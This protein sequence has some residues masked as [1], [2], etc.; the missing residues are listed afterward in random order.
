MASRFQSLLILFLEKQPGNLSSLSLL[1]SKEQEAYWKEIGEKV[2]QSNSKK[3][4]FNSLKEILHHSID[5]FP[6]STVDFLGWNCTLRYEDLG[7]ECVSLSRQLAPVLKSQEKP[8]EEAGLVA[9]CAPPGPIQFLSVVSLIELGRPYLPI[10]PEYPLEQIQ[11]LI[12]DSCVRSVILGKQERSVSE[13]IEI[14]S[15]LS[16]MLVEVDL[17]DS[18]SSSSQSLVSSTILLQPPLNETESL[19]PSGLAYLMYTSGSTGNPKGVC[20][21]HHS[22]TNFC[23]WASEKYEICETDIVLMRS[24]FCFDVYVQ[25]MWCSLFNGADL[26]VADQ[27]TGRDLAKQIDIIVERKVTWLHTFPSMLTTW[28]QMNVNT[29]G[30]IKEKFIDSSL[31]LISCGGEILFE[32]AAEFVVNEI[33]I[34]LD[35]SYGLTESTVTTLNHTMVPH[36]LSSSDGIRGRRE[37]SVPIGKD[38]SRSFH[39]ILDQELR[40]VLPGVPGILHLAGECLAQGYWNKE[41]QNVVSFFTSP[42][43][44][45]LF[46]TGDLVYEDPLTRDVVCVGRRDRQV[47]RRGFRIELD[48]IEQQLAV[49]CHYQVA[50]VAVTPSTSESLQILAFIETT[51]SDELQDW[52]QKL[53]SKIPMFM[54]PDHLYA[55]P[56]LPHLTSGKV[57]YEALKEEGYSRSLESFHFEAQAMG[58]SCPTNYTEAIVLKVWEDVL[59]TSYEGPPDVATSFFRCGGNSLLLVVALSQIASVCGVTLP[60]GWAHEHPTVR[61]WAEYIQLNHEK[62]GEKEEKESEEGHV[63]VAVSLPDCVIPIYVPKWQTLQWTHHT[64]FFLIHSGVGTALPYL[65]ITPSFQKHFGNDVSVY[66]INNPL[67]FKKKNFECIPEMVAHYSSIIE[68]V[69]GS[70]ENCSLFLGGWSFGGILAM[71]IAAVLEKRGRNLAGVVMVDSL[72][73]CALE[74]KTRDTLYEMSEEWT[75]RGVVEPHHILQNDSE[76]SQKMSREG[77][78]LACLQHS[79]VSSAALTARHDL[80]VGP[81]R[82][83]ILLLRATDESLSTLVAPLP[84]DVAQRLFGLKEEEDYGWKRTPRWSDQLPLSNISVK[85]IEGEHN[86]LFDREFSEGTGNAIC[87]FICQVMGW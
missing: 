60:L 24:S 72:N 19:P 67:F 33:G 73:L 36:S 63:D 27:G 28:M 52:V 34:R 40:P 45:R 12:Q 39:L 66:G 82:C 48:E 61:R 46:S 37:G 53:S 76:R 75:F 15:D 59:G 2:R 42:S 54:M 35:N 86:S 64:I 43:G 55:C 68:N 38:V 87:E 65:S 18:L 44:F 3:S 13:Y 1:S 70:D 25:E 32:P 47:K 10:D 17:A 71:E 50:L 56:A 20:V 29:Q 62:E 6:S 31:R 30:G 21:E 77:M 81:S 69:I 79:Y 14:C 7:R 23:E 74:R 58:C 16:V 5:T 51:N 78:P 57:N 41:S 85:E 26:I 84:P 4:R 49:L 9:I 8:N 11:F 83:P 80:P 22:V